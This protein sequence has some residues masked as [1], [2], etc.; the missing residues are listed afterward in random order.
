MHW[1]RAVLLLLAVGLALLAAGVSEGDDPLWRR[2]TGRLTPAIIDDFSGGIDWARWRLESNQ[3]L[4]TCDD[5]GGDVFFSKP[6]G[7]AG[8]WEYIW[9]CLASDL[10]GDFNVS[11]EFTDAGLESTAPGCNNASLWARYGGVK[12]VVIRHDCD[13]GPGGHNAG[14]WVDPPGQ[15]YGIPETAT[16]GLFRM[17]RVGNTVTGY[18]NDI[19]L[20]QG[21]YNGQDVTDLCLALDADHTLD[22]VSVHY[23]N[24]IAFADLIRWYDGFESGD[25][26]AWSAVGP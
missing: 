24:F 9:L 18:F 5:T 17:T 23:D 21:S 10:I 11:I 13:P 14:V 3:P 8:G 6:Y 1:S 12:F 19:V 16:S 25:T 22:A 20:H 7:G 15:W 4:F 2:A 26:S